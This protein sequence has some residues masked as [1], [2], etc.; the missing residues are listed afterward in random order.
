MIDPVRGAS[1]QDR[2]EPSHTLSP[3]KKTEV[4]NIAQDPPHAQLGTYHGQ[5]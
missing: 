5:E 4:D 1:P 2:V 3:Y